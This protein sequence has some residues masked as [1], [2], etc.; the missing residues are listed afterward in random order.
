MVLQVIDRC[1]GGSGH[2]WGD[3]GGE[4]EVWC[5]ATNAIDCLLASCHIA[6]EASK[7][8]CYYNFFSAFNEDYRYLC[9]CA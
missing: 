7:G 1:L 9:H 3:G 2:A 4:D 5:V 6:S 8:L